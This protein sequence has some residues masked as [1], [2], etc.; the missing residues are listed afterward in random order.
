MNQ[1]RGGPAHLSVAPPRSDTPTLLVSSFLLCLSVVLTRTPLAVIFGLAS[2]SL[3]SSSNTV[4]CF[5]RLSLLSPRAQDRHK[6]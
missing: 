5:F 1:G 2:S 3:F 4:A 6:S